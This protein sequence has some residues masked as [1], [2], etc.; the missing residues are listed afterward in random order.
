LS[1][2]QEEAEAL[3]E[4]I[5]T[6]RRRLQTC[7]VCYN[8]TDRQPC[9][10]CQDSGRDRGLLCVVEHPR[11]VA[12]MEKT[13]EFHGIYHVLH[14][15]L[16]PLD[17]IGPDRLRIR[18]LVDRVAAGG[19]REVILATNPDVEGEATALYLGRLLKPLGVRVTRLARGLPE[20]GTLDYADEVTLARALVGRHD[21]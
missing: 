8:W 14:G 6:A 18:E 17:G 12:A 7:T 15:A 20:G 16:S 1:R 21:I 4:A 5:L 13:R 19:I 10:L 11:D 9:P 2:P 3:A